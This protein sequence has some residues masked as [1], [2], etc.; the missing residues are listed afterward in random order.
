MVTVTFFHIPNGVT[1][2]STLNRGSGCRGVGEEGSG[3]GSGKEGEVEVS[4]IEEDRERIDTKYV[5][6]TYL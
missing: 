3:F 4:R 2:V 5:R 1:A 6:S